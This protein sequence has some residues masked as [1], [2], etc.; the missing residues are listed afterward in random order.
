MEW[1]QVKTLNSN[2]SSTKKEKEEEKK[3][4]CMLSE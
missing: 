2:P 4:K 1:L 3:N